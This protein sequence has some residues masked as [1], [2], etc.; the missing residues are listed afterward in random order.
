MI[1]MRVIKPG[2]PFQSSV[3]R[4]EVKNSANAIKR[5]ILADFKKTTAT[6]QHKPTFGYKVDEG[7]A[8]GG[9]R[10]QVATDD[11]IYGFVDE[12]TRKHKIPKYPLPPGKFLAFP[13][14][15]YRAKTKPRVIGSSAGGASGKLVFRKQVTHPG[16]KARKFT[17]TIRDKWKTEFQREMKNALAR[18]VRRCGHG[19]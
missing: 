13:G 12:G 3:F 5:E 17:E 2:K 16:T 1:L 19:I 6:W 4:E 8:V 18:A 15:K 9:V 11:V 7:A 10:I 14:G